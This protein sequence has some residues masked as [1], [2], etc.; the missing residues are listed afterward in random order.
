[1]SYRN[2]TS[3]SLNS[4]L[5]DIWEDARLGQRITQ[6]AV[7]FGALSPLMALANPTGG[8]VVGGQASITAPNGNR[9]VIDQTS[10]NAVINWQQFSVGA[11]QY[12]QFLQPNSSAVVLNRVI[13]NDPSRIFGNISANG[14]VFL[15]NPNGILFGKGAVLDAAGVVA[16]TLDMRDS[17]FM[18]GN[19]MFA[20]GTNAPDAIVLNQGSLSAGR[21][22]YVV[23]AGDYVE[24]DG[25]IQA[26]TGRV[27]LAAGASAT[28]TL[29]RNQLISYTV[30]SATLASLAG[31]VNAGDIVATGG[32]V[33]MTGDV[34]NALTATAVN[35]QGYIGARSI[36]NRSGVIV[37]VG[38]GG[39]TVNSG[40]LDASGNQVNVTGGTILVRSTEETHLLPT[41][42]IDT[43]GDRA[44]GGFVD[45]SGH[46]LGLHGKLNV[47]KG[48]ELL[49]DPSII[50]IESGGASASCSGCEGGIIHT[51]YLQHQL[52]VGVNMTIIASGSIKN[53]GAT[54]ITATAGP[55]AGK[56]AFKIGHASGTI[57]GSL[58]RITSS[59][60]SAHGTSGAH[61]VPTYERQHQ[62]RRPQHQ[63]QGRVPGQ[64]Q[65]RPGDLG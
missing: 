2:S 58:H 42:V 34:A 48:G 33:F 21:G 53:S 46:D 18:Q 9:M 1:M 15:V 7:G 17:D 56:L 16:S 3:I 10:Q 39:E 14:Q 44:N 11:N 65:S 12:V 5:K 52:N 25:R 60:Y 51:N 45:I 8:Q 13:G 64:R 43:E 54:A 63:H 62:P 29:D 49:L 31:V 26:Q 55:G 61:F 6:A 4:R 50:R 19:Y 37:L 41:S 59:I 24:N 40:T 27:Y 36:Q 32:A 38:E 30:D 47:G 28:M 20:K 57:G 22:G 35:N 23:L